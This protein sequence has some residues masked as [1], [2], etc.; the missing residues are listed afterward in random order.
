MYVRVCLCVCI[1]IS[2]KLATLREIKDCY[3]YDECL[4]MLD[5]IH[6]DNYNQRVLEED[7][8]QDG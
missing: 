2:N 5:V 4:A 1:L 6:T 8:T 3:T 7:N